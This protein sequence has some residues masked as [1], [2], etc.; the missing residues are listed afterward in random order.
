M[1]TLPHGTHLSTSINCKWH[2]QLALEREAVQE[3]FR[4]FNL[5]NVTSELHW[6]ILDWQRALLSVWK[7]SEPGHW[8]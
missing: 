7:R 2:V 5:S 6:L 3:P 4:A 8:R 1:N